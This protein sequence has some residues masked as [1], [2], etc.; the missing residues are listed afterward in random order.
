MM[1][2]TATDLRKTAALYLL[3]GSTRKGLRDLTVLS[4]DP[5]QAALEAQEAGA[6]CLLVFDLSEGDASHEASILSLR[7]ICEALEI[8]VVGAGNVRRMEDIKKIL[9]AGC[10]MAALNYAKEGN[11]ALTAEVSAK[12]GK[13]RI[14]ACVTEQD[15]FSWDA[16]EAD[17]LSCVIALD[18]AAAD[19]LEAGRPSRMTLID[20]PAGHTRDAVQPAIAWEDLKKGPDGLVPAIVQEAGT[21][22]VLML[23]YM[24]Q[25][26]YE[27]TCRTGVMTYY[28]R[29]RQSLW[30][31]GETSGHYQY[32]HSLTADCDSD[33][34]LAVVTQIGAACH[35]G[36]HSCF[37][38]EVAQM[39]PLQ[40]RPAAPV[41]AA[42]SGEAKGTLAVLEEDMETIRQRREHPIEGSYT[43]YLFDK[44]I[45]K[46]LK[47][48]GEE[49]TEIVIAAK[50]P[51]KQELVYEIAD[52]LYHL[53]VVMN[54]KG[55]D[56]PDIADELTRRKTEKT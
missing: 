14:A 39:H 54:E 38:R 52:Y 47:K 18:S 10:R 32:V 17:G 1:K 42:P 27:R 34:L 4:E 3:D 31:K 29:S 55:L 9:Y 15:A 43:N 25:E 24:D 49:G 8:P 56:W 53:M 26:A 7:A 41:S 45:D 33:T 40:M 16:P 5:V 12:F 36:S 37:F 19:R 30:I 22:E 21:G 28:S 35:T 44:G 48:L 23:A 6:A 46:M 2:T 20:L 50:N 13:D 51:E 11:R